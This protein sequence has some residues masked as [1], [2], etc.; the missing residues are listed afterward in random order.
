MRCRV[1]WRDEVD[2]AEEPAGDP[3]VLPE[4]WKG[5]RGQKVRSRNIN[6]V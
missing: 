2:G 3:A 4:N 5:G 6:K 1:Y